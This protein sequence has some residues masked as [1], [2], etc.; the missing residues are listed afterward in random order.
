MYGSYK[1]VQKSQADER[2]NEIIRK[3]TPEQRREAI[4]NGT[5]LYQDDPDAMEALRFKSGRN[6]AYEVETEIRNKIA[7]GEF[8]DRQSLVEYRKTRLEDKARAY[9]E[10]SGID[11]NDQAYQRGFNADI[12][13]REAAIYDTHA[14]KLSE[15]TQAIAQMETTSDLGSLFSDEA[16]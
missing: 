8:K 10:A 13:E 6:A 5:L 4:A 15:Q 14:Q 9:A 1:E 3:L 12:L 2:S 16:S 7:M 11:H